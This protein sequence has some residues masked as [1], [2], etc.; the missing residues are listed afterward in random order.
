MS[1]RILIVDDEPS[2]L[3]LFKNLASE[4]L[5]ED[6]EVH[7]TASAQTAI[8]MIKQEE[9]HYIITGLFP[10]E[11]VNGLAVLEASYKKQNETRKAQA[12]VLMSAQLDYQTIKQAEGYDIASVYFKR[13]GKDSELIKI[14][15]R[16]CASYNY[17]TDLKLQTGTREELFDKDREFYFGNTDLLEELERRKLSKDD[18]KLFVETIYD[19]GLRKRHNIHRIVKAVTKDGHAWEVAFIKQYPKEKKISTGIT[20]RKNKSIEE[21]IRDDAFLLRY[22]LKRWAPSTLIYGETKDAIIMKYYPE[23]S[24]DL[25]MT[26]LNKEI[27]KLEKEEQTEAVKKRIEFL[28]AEKRKSIELSDLSLANFSAVMTYFM[29]DK[30]R[31]GHDNGKQEEKKVFD[32]LQKKR[33]DKKKSFNLREYHLNRIKD[34]LIGRA[35]YNYY[36]KKAVENLKGAEEEVKMNLSIL[37]ERELVSSY[38]LPE[39]EVKKLEDM[40]SPIL[41]CYDDP[42]FRAFVQDDFGNTEHIGWTVETD[43]QT[44][45]PVELK[46]VYDLDQCAVDKEHIDILNY[47]ADHINNEGIKKI[48][49]RFN[50]WKVN[51]YN[52]LVELHKAV[53]GKASLLKND[54]NLKYNKPIESLDNLPAR[55]VKSLLRQKDLIMME[56]LLQYSSLG[57][58]NQLTN[59][60]GYNAL[61]RRIV[62]KDFNKFNVKDY[63]IKYKDIIANKVILE[64]Q[65]QKLKSWFNYL[66][67]KKLGAPTLDKIRKFRDYLKEGFVINGVKVP[68]VGDL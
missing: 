56:V 46:I 47:L 52:K 48:N 27:S 29:E 66:L 42:N 14:I 6:V 57:C 15:K 3:N 53:P 1:L 58:W 16:D 7:D 22:A 17:R 2:T 21:R 44:R 39:N 19:R 34:A 36:E 37:S 59:L 8:E 38:D 50:K 54:Y 10:K 5:G 26:V 62:R 11:G 40:V 24:D 43:R 32:V 28:A 12:R 25:E 31:Y 63:E 9:Y 41:E 67:E 68:I 51:Q 18:V 4:H 64:T 60:I 55:Y 33:F 65:D 13:T 23:P 35:L 49:E 45:Q 20:G 61:L 30:V